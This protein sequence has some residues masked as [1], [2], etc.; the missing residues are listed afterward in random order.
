MIHFWKEEY[1][2]AHKAELA[3]Y[4]AMPIPGS[5]E[6][7]EFFV[8]KKIQAEYPTRLGVYE[9]GNAYSLHLVSNDDKEYPPHDSGSLYKDLKAKLDVGLCLKC[10]KTNDRKDQGECICSSCKAKAFGR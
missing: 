10:E 3:K 5:R 6:E 8:N 7:H 9:D 4:Q 2:P 1:T